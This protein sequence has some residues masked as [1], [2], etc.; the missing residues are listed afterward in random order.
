MGITP[1]MGFRADPEIRAAI[2]RWADRTSPV[3]PKPSAASSSGGCTSI[4]KR[5]QKAEQRGRKTENQA[6]GKPAERRKRCR[7][8]K[9]FRGSAFR[10]M[11]ADSRP[12][13]SAVLAASKSLSDAY[14][15]RNA[16]WDRQGR[17]ARAAARGA[18]AAPVRFAG[19][20][21]P[22]TSPGSSVSTA[23]HRYHQPSA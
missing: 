7:N 8:D 6:A 17:W 3:F 12:I 9:R 1:L 18:G 11:L 10:A 14:D 19:L 21:R 13:T 22:T 20:G 4:R 2:I 23:F 15:V 5:A 16:R